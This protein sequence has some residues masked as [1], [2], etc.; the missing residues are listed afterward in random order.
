M[1]HAVQSGTLRTGAAI[2]VATKFFALVDARRVAI[3]GTGRNALRLVEAACR[4]RPVESV[5]VYSR[6]AE[7]RAAFAQR[8]Q[9]TL[10]LAAEPVS[11]IQAATRGAETIYAATN[12]L[13]P[14][15]YGDS[16]R[17]GVFV[18]SMGRSSEIDP[19]V[20]LSARRIVVGDKKHE[21]G[22]FALGQYRHQLLE[23]VHDGKVKWASVAEM[24]EVVAGQGPA[25]TSTDEIIIFKE[26]GG[27][28]GDVAFANWI[29]AQARNKGLGREWDFS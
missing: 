21:E 28:F 26:S 2:A 27:G 7:R 11:E 13:T 5:M 4:V 15:L 3:I 1:R 10:G 17:S 25:R 6:N 16:L 22:Y 18:A 12:S 29:Y 14:V 19:S 9:A 23:L 20:Y 8:A 24:C